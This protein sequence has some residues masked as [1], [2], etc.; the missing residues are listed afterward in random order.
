MTM[1]DD[2]VV[3]DHNLKRAL[4]VTGCRQRREN[5]KE[6]GRGRGWCVRRPTRRSMMHLEA[7]GGW[8]ACRALRLEY[9]K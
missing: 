2:N 3:A 8:G 4:A 6:D 1:Q 9:Q 7:E 5:G